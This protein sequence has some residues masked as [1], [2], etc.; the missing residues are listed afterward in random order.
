M[1]IPV[2]AP[3]N[4]WFDGENVDNISLNLE[5]SY[6]NQIESGIINNHF[7]SGVLPSELVPNVLF[8][9][10]LANGL[11]DGTPVNAQNQ[12]LDTTNG[13][14]LAVSLSG[15]LAAGKRTVK[16]LIIGL[17]FQSN[18]Q[19]SALTFHTNETQLTSKHYTEV[20]TILFNDFIGPP[21]QSFNL[22][23]RVIIEE[24]LPFQMSRDVLTASQNVEPNLF[25]R[26][27]FTPNN[28]TLTGVLSAALPNYNINAL[29]IE[30]G[31]LTLQSL[32]EN[33]VSSQI[34]QKF[35][36]TVNNIQKITLL[37]SVIN[38]VTPSN[39]VWDGDIL[40]SIYPLQSVV[41][42]PTDLVP[43]TA[44]DYD[45][46]NIPVAQLSFDYLSLQS[47]GTVLNTVPQPVDFIFSNTTV[48]Q[49]SVIIPGNYYAVTIKRAGS[50][51]TCQIQ[52]A[53][54]TNSSSTQQETLFNGS[55][56][57]DIPEQSL[58]FEVWSD[59]AKVAS[60]Q[61]YDAG[62]GMVI[63]Q[64][65]VNPSTGA[66]QDYVL[67][68]LPFTGNAVFYALAQATTSQFAPVQDERTGNDVN[69]EQQN[70]P[71]VTL[72]N[73]AG[74]A[75]IQNV[76]TPF[77]IGTISDQNVKSFTSNN[78]FIG[79]IHEYGMVKNQLVMKVV[80]N[81]ND[82][83]RYD[84]N[85]IELL[86]TIVN[87]Q[88]NGAQFIPNVANPSL[89]YRVA[90]AEII[91]MIYG[92]VDG[93]GVVTQN[94]ILAMQ[95]LL[96]ANLNVFP[97]YQQYIVQT[98]LFVNDVSLSW[99][100]VNPS[101]NSIIASGTDGLLVVNPQNGAQANF[102]SLS[103]NFSNITNLNLYQLVILNSSTSAGNNGSF[104][105]VSLIATNEITIQKM[106]YTS[107]TILELMR[108]DVDGDMVVDAT[109]LN[110]IINYID[111][112]PPFPPITPPENNVGTPFQ[113]IRL[114]FEEYV[115]R[116]DDY[117]NLAVN[118]NLTV[119]PEPDLFLDG[120]FSFAN[121]NVELHPIQF[122]AKEQ[123]VW[124]DSSVVV[125]STPRE[126]PCAFTYE[127]G[128][129]P[130]N[131]CAPLEGVVSQTFPEPPAFD[132]GRNDFFIPDNLVMNF[133]SNIINPD[134]YFYKVDFEMSTVVIEIPADGY[135]GGELSVN[136]FTDFVANFSNTGYTRI[137]YPAMQFADCT[138][139]SMEGLVNNQVRFAV[140][141]QSFSPQLFGLD[142]SCISGIIVDGKIGVS[143]DYTTGILTLNFTNLYQDPVLQTLNTKIQL[144][145][146][147]KKAGWNN[148]PIYMNS[149]RTYNWLGVQ[150][151]QPNS[152][153]CPD[154]T[155]VILS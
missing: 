68:D 47:A 150:T 38:D 134:G 6:N 86:S 31:Y 35:L 29:N 136:L 79:A 154:P 84:T 49:G 133:G 104:Q 64:N 16:V 51:D 7:G 40:V 122:N 66:E 45:P 50:A 152:L 74:L 81:Q 32:V 80:T 69:S 43:T 56:W 101:N 93:D 137:G 26:D 110:A 114:T 9:S 5:Q 98:T 123:L 145:V 22:G 89:F 82:G 135:F 117:S 125:N 109:D 52:V 130:P 1:R 72:Y 30:T 90:R 92:D 111:L 3:Q 8:D 97:S 42:C 21:Q 27:F 116:A 60:G 132:P 71:T 55:I 96:G 18:L 4:I 99:Q 139:V 155:M 12:P 58:W 151:P 34:G 141:V 19:Y 75:N 46:N 54:G 28:V 83:Y 37:L 146:Y 106:Y 147:L 94:D 41:S 20:L 36:A 103:T 121:Q 112:V 85:I 124:Y 63:P 118:R 62:H 44:I 119:H 76:S 15:S 95:N 23:G 10:S 127:S 57:T 149:V 70:I 25:F 59:S 143:M 142:P 17:D 88:L 91:T 140:A 113:C 11:L 128:A 2:S 105:I 73:A 120:Y 100:L 77:I 78:T 115:D 61:A 13:V 129:T 148:T 14:Q 102:Q 107:D 126:V 39:L 24:A 144:T 87:G 65:Q 67:N 131:Q 108:A 153:V 33:D 53:V 138:K 48:A